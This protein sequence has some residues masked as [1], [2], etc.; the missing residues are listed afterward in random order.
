MRPLLFSMPA[1]IVGLVIA[2]LVVQFILQFEMPRK[3]RLVAVAAGLVAVAVIVFRYRDS[4][5]PLHAYGV[6]LALASVA[7][8]TVGVARAPLVGFTKIET[9]DFGLYV[10]LWGVVGA[11]L[12][13]VFENL[14]FYFAGPQAR[15]LLGALAVWNGGLVFYGGIMGAM[16]Y[17]IYFAVRRKDGRGT[18]VRMFDLGAPC[19]MYGLAF[20]RVGCFLN[21]CCYGSPTS[22]PWAVAYPGGHQYA[23]PLWGAIFQGGSRSA[24]WKDLLSSGGIA[25]RMMPHTFHVHPHQLYAS[26]TALAIGTF[27]SWAFYKKWR[28]GT[29]SV[30]TLLTY[31]VARFVFEGWFRGDTPRVFASL[32]FTISQYVSVVALVAGLVWGGLLLRARRLDAAAAAA[33][34]ARRGKGGGR[35]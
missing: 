7:A 26:A 21:G 31:P 22:L 24:Q 35:G 28:S 1:W 8:I 5:L 23:S 16:G 12:F 30:L 6:M 29:V 13:H 11:R 32:P 10:V 34:P 33:A 15:G 14:E 25:A 17:T 4:S 27:L 18:L 20:G 19:V 2:P 9:V 3:W